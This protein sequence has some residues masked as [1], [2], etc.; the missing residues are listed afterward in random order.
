MKPYI[1]CHMLSSI[2]GRIKTQHW[3]QLKGVE[4]YEKTG[5]QEKA[6][7][8]MCG[9]VT[10]QQHYAVELPELTYT[11]PA[12]NREDHI[13]DNTAP[14]YSITID[15]AGKLGWEKAY[16]DN[17]HIIIVL[18]ESVPD[19]YLAYLQEKGVSYIFGGK[20]ELDFALVL[21]KLGQHFNIK[22]VLLE[23]GGGINGSFHAAGLIDEYSILVFP[24]ADGTNGPTLLDTNKEDGS[25]PPSQLSLVHYELLEGNIIWVRYK[26]IR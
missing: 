10:M 12:I 2:D 7:A 17:D 19:A 13:A 6:D 22:K 21:D 15:P 8:W 25:I 5:K 24:V 1:I 23:G 4:Y 20:D 3:G 26:V 16:I 18:A 11:G 14:S 9:R